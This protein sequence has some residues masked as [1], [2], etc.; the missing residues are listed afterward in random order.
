MKIALLPGL[1]RELAEFHQADVAEDKT[2]ESLNSSKMAQTLYKTELSQAR[3]AQRGAVLKI[4]GDSEK[5]AL[6]T[7]PW[8]KSA[9]P[10]AKED[11]PAAPLV[12][13]AGP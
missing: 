3:E 12:P 5:M 10:K 1:E 7:L 11:E 8:R 13:P 4:V 6:F 2:R 9:K